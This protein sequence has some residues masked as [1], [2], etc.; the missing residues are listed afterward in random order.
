MP[1]KDSHNFREGLTFD[2]VLL[3]PSFSQ[4]MPADVDVSTSLT[5]SIRLHIP[6]LSAAMD[7]VTE[8]KT[9]ICLAQEGGIG[10]IHR[11]M[12]IMEQAQEVEKRDDH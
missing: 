11:N 12:G 4:I 2:D 6:I 10:I 7:T 5:N 9:A 3:A 1:E 8:S